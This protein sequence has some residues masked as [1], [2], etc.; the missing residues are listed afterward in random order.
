MEFKKTKYYANNRAEMLSFIPLS[1]KKT[2]EIGCG[3]GN[4]SAQLTEKGIE[5]WGVEPNIDSA[6]IAHQKLHTILTGTL[7][8]VINQLPENYFDAIIMNDILEH[9]LFPWENMKQ[10]KDKLTNEGVL[11][12]SIP[13]VR[14]AKNM[15]HLLFMKNWE[16]KE[17]GI[18]DSTHFRFF[19][20]KSIISM[21][22][23]SGYS[24]QK[25]KGINITKSVLFFPFAL[26][27]NVILLF[28]QM[29]IFY[30]QFATV[31][32]KVNSNN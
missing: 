30:M 10:L 24:I 11:I 29:D 6:K 16:Y 5:T 1:A 25:I 31:A 17:S 8:E 3:Q 14:Y 7:D 12:S 20:K 21:H 32:K 13:N 9:L 28:T 2:L 26:L 4:F 23:K 27:V 15:F 22:K 18:L 19:T